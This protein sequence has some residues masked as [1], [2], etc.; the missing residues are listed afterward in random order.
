MQDY[1]LQR[2]GNHQRDDDVDIVLANDI[3]MYPDRFV[4]DKN[5]IDFYGVEQES[6]RK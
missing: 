5:L 3:D 4:H 1:S 2:E 6:H